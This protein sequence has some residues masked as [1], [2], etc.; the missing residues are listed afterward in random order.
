[1]KIF[2]TGGTGNIGQYVTLAAVDGGHEAVVLTRSPEKYPSMAKKAELVKGVITNY[3]LMAECIKGC[4]AVMHIALGWGDEPVSML[5]SDTAATVK[6][7]EMSEKAGVKKFIYTS[8]TAAMGLMRPVMEESMANIP[9]DLYGSTKAAS[10]AYVLGFRK[11]YGNGGEVSMKRNIIRPGYTFSTP[12]WEDGVTQPDSRFRDIADAI[13]NDEPVVLTKHDGTQFISAQDI[14]QLY[15]RLI[16]SDKNEEVY[17]AL[18]N[19]FTSWERIA[20]AA[21]DEYPSSK[22]EIALNDLGWSEQP[23][24]FDIRKMQRD[25]GLSFDCQKHLHEHIKWNL[26]EAI[27]RKSTQT[28]YSR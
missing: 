28:K 19:M 16:E 22:S 24:M 17:L 8:S 26:A 20:M 27:K 15:I 13:V 3:E 23:M 11:Y 5:T 14:A 10:E 25:F 2:I 12:P 9:T 1:M 7:L 18:A 21:L 6:L 4:D